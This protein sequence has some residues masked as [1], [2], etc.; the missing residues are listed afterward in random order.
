MWDKL[1]HELWRERFISD[2]TPII[3]GILCG[4]AFGG[5]LFLIAYFLL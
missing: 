4:G 1:R 2:F 5:L 3:L